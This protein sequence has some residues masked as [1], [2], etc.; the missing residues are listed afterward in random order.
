MPSTQRSRS[1]GGRCRVGEVGSCGA[2]HQINFG[3]QGGPLGLAMVGLLVVRVFGEEKLL[4]RDL[5][6][7]EE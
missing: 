5:E 6:G 2:Y 1:R 7:Y 3:S 4:A